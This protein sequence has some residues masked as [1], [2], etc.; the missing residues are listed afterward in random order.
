MGN[1]PEI[2]CTD[3]IYEAVQDRW[4]IMKLFLMN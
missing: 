2:G 3:A 1:A 4:E